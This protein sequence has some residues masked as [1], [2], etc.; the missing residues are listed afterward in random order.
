[1]D[2]TRI[3][4][5]RI[6]VEVDASIELMREV[7]IRDSEGQV[8]SVLVDYNWEPDCCSMCKCFGHSNSTRMRDVQGPPLLMVKCNFMSDWIEVQRKHKGKEVKVDSSAKVGP[9]VGRKGLKWTIKLCL[10]SQ[11]L[12][13]VA[14]KLLMWIAFLL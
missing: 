8:F 9:L 14:K 10:E 7:E 13:Q 2:W 6:C 1:M 12:G 11:M 3:D 5:A 4:F